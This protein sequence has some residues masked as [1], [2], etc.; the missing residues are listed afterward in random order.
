MTF[1]SPGALA[2]SWGA[3]GP[4]PIC[5]HCQGL[6][7]RPTWGRLT[8]GKSRHGRGHRADARRHGRNA[9]LAGEGHPGGEVADEGRGLRICRGSK[10]CEGHRGTSTGDEGHSSKVWGAGW[11]DSRPAVPSLRGALPFLR[12]AQRRSRV[13][14]VLMSQLS[15]TSC[16]QGCAFGVA[17]SDLSSCGVQPLW[18]LSAD[19]RGPGFCANMVSVLGPQTVRAMWGG[20]PEQPVSPQLHPPHQG[21]QGTPP[22]TEAH[23]PPWLCRHLRPF[24]LEVP[25][26]QGVSHL[27]LR[28]SLWDWSKVPESGPRAVW[29]GTN[30]RMSPGRMSK[31]VRSHRS[32]NL[33]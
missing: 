32:P 33:L 20:S 19:Q 5:G 4:A 23:R 24:R 16:C 22:R 27:D 6:Q 10:G 1:L 21:C 18:V 26:N 3:S 25:G 17:P 8:G 2:H 9:G 15:L 29:D 30:L 31:T 14:L 28:Q 11:A 13:C 12:G 7:S